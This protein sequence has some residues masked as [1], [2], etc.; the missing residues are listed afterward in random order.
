MRI[1][2]LFVGALL[3]AIVGTGCHMMSSDDG[4]VALFDGESIDQGWVKRGGKA[5]YRVEENAIVGT[6]AP[7]TPNTFLCTERD[8]GDFD[9]ILE[10]KVDSSMNSGVQFRSSY[11]EEP[12]TYEIGEK[13]INVPARVVHGYQCEIDPSD[14]RWTA[15][16]YDE[17]RSGWLFN[18]KNKPEAG[19]AFKRDEWNEMRIRTEGSHIQTWINGVPA[20]DFS[21]DLTPKGFI[22][23]QV[24]GVGDRKEP[25]E[26]RWR[27]IRIKEL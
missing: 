25:M 4:F 21:D 22:A 17:S 2:F 18:L 10:F 8:Y 13:K 5:T 6:T 16:V 26:I 14:R 19:A 7:N 20:A 12:T 15:G 3:M 27:N 24:H 1:S 9:L 23:L 11:F